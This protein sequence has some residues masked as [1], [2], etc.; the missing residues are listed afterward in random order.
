MSQDVEYILNGRYKSYGQC[1]KTI[2]VYVQ[3]DLRGFTSRAAAT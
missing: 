1:V 2:K 3:I